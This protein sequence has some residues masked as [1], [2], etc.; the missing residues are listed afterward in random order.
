MSQKEKHKKAK[1]LKRLKR[2][3]A[4]DVVAVS[5]NDGGDA[6]YETMSF[7][8]FDDELSDEHDLKVGDP[9]PCCAKPLYE[10]VITHDELIEHYRKIEKQ[11]ETETWQNRVKEVGFEQYKL[12]LDAEIAE[13]QRVR[14]E[15]LRK[16]Y[17]SER[18]ETLDGEVF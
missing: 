18:F 15:Q 5:D 14:R 6:E 9:C 2:G 13:V 7:A 11:E 3:G 16:K 8:D 10:R 17:P 1:L 4:A 12:E